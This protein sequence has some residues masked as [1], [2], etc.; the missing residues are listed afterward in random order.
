MELTPELRKDPA[1][2]ASLA[3]LLA[4]IPELTVFDRSKH[5]GSFEIQPM[6]YINR[7]L[8]RHAKAFPPA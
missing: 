6:L 2:A 7:I 5:G 3:T 4:A 1:L 8:I